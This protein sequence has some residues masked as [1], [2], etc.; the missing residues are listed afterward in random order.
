MLSVVNIKNGVKL[1]IT[2]EVMVTMIMMMMVMVMMMAMMMMM[3]ADSAA[4]TSLAPFSVLT[5]DALMAH[6][7]NPPQDLMHKPLSPSLCHHQC[8][9][10]EHS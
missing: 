2:M 6:L 5:R 4:Q 8:L 10:S 3:K 1:Y 7:P 9:F